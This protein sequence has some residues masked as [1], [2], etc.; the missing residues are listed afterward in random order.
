MILYLIVIAF[1]V[2]CI[3]DVIRRGRNSIWIMALVFL[4][5]ASGIAYFIVE[6]LPG[7]QGNR[8]VRQARQKI[9]DKMD[10]ERELRAAQQALEVA[11][12]MANRLRVADA[13]TALGRHKDALPL[14]R[15]GAGAR[16]DFRTAEKLARS[17]F[18]ND[19]SQD[20]LAAVDSL[21]KVTAQSDLDRV[22]LLRARI[23]EDLGRNDEALSDYAAVVDRIPGDEARCRYA[24]LLLKLNRNAEARQVLEDVE[25][26]MKYLDRHTRSAEAPMYDW[27]MKQLATL[28]T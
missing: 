17:L 14:Y 12:T 24:A 25:H 28:R 9:A 6:I 26:R 23:L 11:D 22:K 16:P 3:V 7:L 2:Y 5:V 20:A 10:P 1:Q 4:P 21:P 13:L 15:S 18:L 27:A 8:H 19:R